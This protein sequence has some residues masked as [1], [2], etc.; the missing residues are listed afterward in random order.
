MFSIELPYDPLAESLVIEAEEWRPV[1]VMDSDD[2]RKLG[3]AVRTISL[4]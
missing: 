2:I 1:D 3:L 4:L